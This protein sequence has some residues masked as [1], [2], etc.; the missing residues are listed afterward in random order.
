[1][2]SSLPVTREVD[3]TLWPAGSG[4]GPT[5]DVLAHLHV[6]GG[7]QSVLQQPVLPVT[8]K[9]APLLPLGQCCSAGNLPP[10]HRLQLLSNTE[11]ETELDPY[12]APVFKEGVLGR[13]C[14]PSPTY[15]SLFLYVWWVGRWCTPSPHTDP[16]FSML[17]CREM[18][19]PLP[20]IQILIS[21]CWRVG[22][23]FSHFSEQP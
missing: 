1:M 14:T 19:Y 18:V 3:C 2:G 17:A 22:P 15:R 6:T 10:A 20:H 21:L 11:W 4:L 7:M 13:W 5:W 23:I 16:Y 12:L 9:E 8:A